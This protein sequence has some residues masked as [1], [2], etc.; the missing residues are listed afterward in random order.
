MHG[1]T[2]RLTMI[3]I[4]RDLSFT[5]RC[6]APSFTQ[7][8]LVLNILKV[9]STL[10]RSTRK[11]A[12]EMTQNTLATKNRGFWNGESQISHIN[13]KMSRLLQLNFD[14]R[15][16]SNVPEFI[17]CFEVVNLCEKVQLWEI[18]GKRKKI[19]GSYT[20]IYICVADYIAVKESY[21][22]KKRTFKFKLCVMQSLLHLNVEF[23]SILQV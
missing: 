21:E 9:F 7:I 6:I 5:T 12:L 14:L 17:D 13:V 4:S 22:N 15:G 11:V 2:L 18:V 8:L 3:S 10:F 23:L 19:C 1:I 20:P 16:K